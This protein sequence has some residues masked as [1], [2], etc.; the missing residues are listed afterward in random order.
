[1]LAFTSLYT[2]CNMFRSLQHH[3]AVCPPV[4]PRL[5]RC[6]VLGALAQSSGQ[7]AL[8]LLYCHGLISFGRSSPSLVSTAA[9]DL[10]TVMHLWDLDSPLSHPHA[11][12]DCCCRQRRSD[13]LFLRGTDF[14]EARLVLAS[15]VLYGGIRD[16][17]LHCPAI[18]RVLIVALTLA[19]SHPL[20]VRSFLFFLPGVGP[21]FSVLLTRCGSALFCSFPPTVGPLSSAL[22]HS[23]VCRGCW[24]FSLYSSVRRVLHDVLFRGELFACAQHA[25]SH[26]ARGL[27]D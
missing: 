19:C 3:Q 22:F 15:H 25:H 12:L 1:M 10:V 14:S 27:L 18:E 24:D 20:W 4:R 5:C 7:S 16:L 11:R 9:H 23:G 6:V 17:V 2:L 21:H 26:A 13:R 8:M